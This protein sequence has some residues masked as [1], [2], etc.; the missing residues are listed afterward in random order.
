MIP[1]WFCAD[2]L[3]VM[4]VSFCNIMSRSSCAPTKPY[5]AARARA[6]ALTSTVPSAL[7][8]TPKSRRAV[9]T[10]MSPSSTSSRTLLRIA[11]KRLAVPTTGR[12]N[13]HEAVADLDLRVGHLGR[14]GRDLTIGA[15]QP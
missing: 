14:Q 12:T 13:A 2:V 1:G 15:F 3:S 4:D 11:G 6:V 7:M 8:T 5:C 10:L 9:S